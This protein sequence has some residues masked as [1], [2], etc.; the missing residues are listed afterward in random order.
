M[1]FDDVY[2]FGVITY[3]DIIHI[4]TAFDTWRETL[5]TQFILIAKRVTESM[6]PCGTPIS[7][8]KTSDV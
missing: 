3:Y 7:W 2:K 1:L 4:E 5:T 8:A 6:L